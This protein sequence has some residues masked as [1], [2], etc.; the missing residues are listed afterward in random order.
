MSFLWVFSV[1]EKGM[2]LRNVGKE[3]CKF[4]KLINSKLISIHDFCWIRLTSNHINLWPVIILLSFFSFVF[5]IVLGNDSEHPVLLTIIS[6]VLPPL[7]SG[8]FVRKIVLMTKAKNGATIDT[9]YYHEPVLRRGN[10][11]D[12][13]NL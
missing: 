8:L 12:D 10:R 9:H 1:K 6:I 11:S 2:L 3:I 4:Y 13:E 7:F 5:C